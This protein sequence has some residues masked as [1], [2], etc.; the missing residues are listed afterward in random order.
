MSPRIGHQLASAQPGYWSYRAYERRN[1][2]R[3]EYLYFNCPC[4]CEYGDCVPIS[5]KP[6]KREH[7]WSWNGSVE[8]PTL[9]PSLRRNTPCKWHGHLVDGAWTN[10]GDGA[11]NAANIYRAGMTPA[12]ETHVTREGNPMAESKNQGEDQSQEDQGDT[13]ENP[14]AA[15]HA[16]TW[17]AEPTGDDPHRHVCTDCG[18]EKSENPHP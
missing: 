14:P 10:V 3:F 9:E 11:P 8:R 7:H 6:P 16:H 2:E 17:A 15:E 5:Q 12:P 13:A 4:G 18:E 1:G